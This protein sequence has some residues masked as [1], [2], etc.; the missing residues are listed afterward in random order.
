MG[1]TIRMR[2]FNNV[3]H[4]DVIYLKFRDRF[5]TTLTMLD[6]ESKAIK[7]N[8]LLYCRKFSAFVFAVIITLRSKDSIF[9]LVATWCWVDRGHAYFKPTL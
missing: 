1:L 7:E 2:M 6:L 8:L 4:F 9:L 3:K 5:F